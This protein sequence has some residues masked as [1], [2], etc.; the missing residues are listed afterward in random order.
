VFFIKYTYG[1][2]KHIGESHASAS[3]LKHIIL[4]D[5]MVLPL[6]LQVSFKS[7]TQRSVIVHSCDTSINL[8][9]LNEE[10]FTLEEVLNLLSH[11]LLGEVHRLFL[12]SFW[13]LFIKIKT[14]SGILTAGF[15]FSFSIVFCII[16]LFV[17]LLS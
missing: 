17:Q 16:Y 2:L 5:E 12:L 8:E 10:E 7:G 4:K 14:K 6:L 11:V 9:S 1:C 13:S 15:G 3:K